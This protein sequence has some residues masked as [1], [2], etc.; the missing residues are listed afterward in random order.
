MTG[1]EECGNC[2]EDSCSA[3]VKQAGEREQDYQDRQQLAGRMC[4]IKHKIIVMSGKGGVGKSTVAVNLAVSLSMKGHRVGLLDVDIHG[5]SVPTLLNLEDRQIQGNGDALTPIDFSEKLKVMSIG[6]MLQKR[7]DA[8]IWRGPMKHNVIKQFLKD[9]EWGDLDYL[10]IDSPPGTG[11]EPMAVCQFVED[12]DGAIIVTMPQ[13]VALMDV[14]KSITFCQQL[15]MKVLGVIENMSGFSCP[16]CGEILEM[17]PSGGASNMAMQM[18]VPFLGQIPMDPYVASACDDGTP[19]VTRHA[20]SLTTAAFMSAIK[21]VLNGD[22]SD[23]VVNDNSIYNNEREVKI[24]RIAIPIAEGKLA[25]HFGHCEQFALIDVE[26]DEKKIVG[27]VTETPPPHEPGVLPKWLSE[28]GANVIIAGGMG[29]R[30]QNLFTEQSIE[31]VVG[32]SADSPEQIVK[33]YMDGTLEAGENV[34]DH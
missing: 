33:A 21:T 6:F 8:V 2:A 10:I 18:G 11:D 4:K 30:A 12:A 27:S 5:P 26:I 23:E 32:A 9:V 14:R 20:D 28:K 3:K 25:M 24:M 15:K 7:D 17:F 16:K 34:C 13:E 22:N 31:V 29:S 19:Y 1:T